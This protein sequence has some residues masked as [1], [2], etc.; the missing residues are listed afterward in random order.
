L[1]NYKNPATWCADEALGRSGGLT[2]KLHLAVDGRGL[3]LSVLLS[4]GQTHDNPLLLPVLQAIQVPR[5]AG[6]R[7]SRPDHVIADKAYS[8][9]STRHALRARGIRHTIPER[10]DQ[11]DRRARRGQRGGRPPLFDPATYRRRNVVER[12]V[13]RLKQW[14]GIATRYDKRAENYR[15][16]VLLAAIVLWMRT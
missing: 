4:A 2:S 7:R 5:A 12:C 3:P 8:H 10:A 16:G 15:S 1:S 14:R 13:N 11:I 6:R 9:P